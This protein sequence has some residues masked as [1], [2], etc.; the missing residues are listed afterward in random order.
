M[1]TAVIKAYLQLC[2]ARRVSGTAQYP[3]S[4]HPDISL[5]SSLSSASLHAS[6]P[7]DR[8]GM[9]I[10]SNG[11]LCARTRRARHE[12]PGD[13]NAVRQASGAA[14]TPNGPQR[15]NSSIATS[16]FRPRVSSKITPETS[17]AVRPRTFYPNA[18]LCCSSRPTSCWHGS[19][20]TSRSSASAVDSV[21][22]QRQHRIFGATNLVRLTTA[23]QE[24]VG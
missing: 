9:S 12:L 22:V 2:A 15:S 5:E 11:S 19:C 24:T 23:G 1:L 16:I 20:A 6:P 21:S 14:G 18:L 17:T 3:S 13:R 10:P 4:E 8:D 7:R